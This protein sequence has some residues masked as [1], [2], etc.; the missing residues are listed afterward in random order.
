[1]TSNREREREW[2]SSWRLGNSRLLTMITVVKAKRVKLIDMN[3]EAGLT[4]F[5][6]RVTF[7]ESIDWS[8]PIVRL[9]DRLWGGTNEQTFLLPRELDKAEN[10]LMHY[11]HSS[12]RPAP[13]SVI[14]IRIGENHSQNQH[15]S[16][17][18]GWESP[19]QRPSGNHDQTPRLLE[20][21]K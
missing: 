2:R 6:A 11:D 3:Q 12:G 10:I 21:T 14:C 19:S 15:C 20:T 18:G 13:H 4:G 16:R 1:M 7:M 8:Q 9:R 17:Q 5:L